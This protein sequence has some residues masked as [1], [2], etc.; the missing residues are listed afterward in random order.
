[1]VVNIQNASLPRTDLIIFENTSNKLHN[2]DMD[3][4]VS[5]IAALPNC[6]DTAHFY[7]SGLANTPL[8]TL[9]LVKRIYKK[10]NTKMFHL[11]D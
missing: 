7:S 1:M 4:Y 3:R 6:L 11:N 9:T 10:N 8:S 5:A 2:R